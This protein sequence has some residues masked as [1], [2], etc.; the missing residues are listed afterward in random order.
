MSEFHLRTMTDDDR[1]EV[2]ELI[3]ASLNV[4]HMT[5]GR[6]PIFTAG[7]QSCEVFYDVYND[8]TPGKNVVAVNEPTGRLAGSCY[9][10]PRPNHVSLGIMAVHPN[11]WGK[12]IGGRLLQHIIDFANG[13]GLPTI[14][15]TQS[16]ISVDSYS[17]YNRYGFIPRV[18]FQD[19]LVTVPEG[20]L[21]LAV[22]LRDHVRDAVPGDV[23][24][25]VDL[26]LD[27]SGLSRQLDWDYCIANERGMWHVSVLESPQGEI[28]G[29]I[30]SVRHPAITMLGPAVA[31]TEEQMIALFAAELDHHPGST[32]VFLVPSERDTIVRQV[33][34]W[35][36]KNC[37][38]HFYQSRG[39]FQPFQGVSIPSFLPE[40]G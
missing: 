26:E 6:G 5:H 15:L 13:A 29:L 40:T 28:D 37:E 35:G 2:G 9:F 12:G 27:V 7:P 34:E 33:Y 30:V 1:A 21:N 10:H 39:E 22:P 14:R 38:L 18:A 19:M 8:L 17:L 31:R 36:G 24:D 11:Y 20:G 3:Y 4:W 23:E 32:P 16:A 25:M